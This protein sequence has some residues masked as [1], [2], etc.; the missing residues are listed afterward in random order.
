MPYKQIECPK[1]GSGS[2]K[3]GT[4]AYTIYED[5]HGYCFSCEYYSPPNSKSNNGNIKKGNMEKIRG[6]ATEFTNIAER[7]IAR[8]VAEKYG[9]TYYPDAAKNKRDLIAYPFFDSANKHI[10]NEIRTRHGSPKFYW[11][12]DKNNKTKKLFGQ[13]LF[14]EGS[15]PT[16]TV[17]EGC[18]DAMAVYQMNGGYPCVAVTSVSTARKEIA[19]NFEYLNTFDNIVIC[20]DKDEPKVNERTGEVRYPG[21]EAANIVAQMFQIGKAKVLTLQEHKDANEYLLA[22]HRKAF[23]KEWYNAPTFTPTGLKM[24]KDMWEEIKNPP[25]YESIPYPFEGLQEKTLG[26][27]LSELTIFT[28]ETGVG[29]TQV[30]KEIEHWILNNTKTEAGIGLMH[31]EETNVDTAL[32]L[33]SLTANKPLHIPDVRKDVDEEELRSYFEKTLDDDRVVIWDHFGSNDI[34]EVL[35]KVRHMHN[36][37]CK[38]IILDHLSIIVSDQRGD[39]RKQLDEITTKLKTLCME[40]NVAIL[41]V[42]HLNRQGLI[43]GTAAIE[44]LAN[45]VIRLDRDKTDPD[46]WRRNVTELTVEKNRFTGDSGPACFLFYNRDSGRLEELTDEEA[47][48]FRAGKSAEPTI[49]SEEWT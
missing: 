24:A 34:E 19:A 3:S 30:L 44:Q 45:V 8:E 20:F 12:G 41:A 6:L 9:V 4:P 33:M 22:G 10:A 46:D 36:L 2:N 35:A 49:D 21:Q 39:E 42:V 43:R 37:G 1:C 48:R 5:G 13:Q 17:V 29:K 27:R 31:L 40:L 15:A 18:D 32:G 11:E 23:M 7:G 28:A 14:P 16:I 26:L 38:Y 47:E 25:K